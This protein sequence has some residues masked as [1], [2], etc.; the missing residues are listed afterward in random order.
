MLYVHLLLR[1]FFSLS[2]RGMIMRT[3]T[4]I[5]TEIKPDSGKIVDIGC[6]KVD[7]LIEADIR[8]FK[9]IDTL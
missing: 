6:I 5:D 8:Y 3:R 1:G 7:A 2:K 9:F 4:F